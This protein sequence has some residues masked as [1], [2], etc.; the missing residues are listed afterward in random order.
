MQEATLSL[1]SNLGL[2]LW[3]TAVSGEPQGPRGCCPESALE[4]G[5]ASQ[6]ACHPVTLSARVVVRS[7]DSKAGSLGAFFSTQAV[8]LVP[9]RGGRSAVRGWSLR[10]PSPV[11]TVLAHTGRGTCMCLDGVH[12]LSRTRR[13][14]RCVQHGPQTLLTSGPRPPWR[15][16][17]G[18]RLPASGSAAGGAGTTE[19][20]FYLEETGLVLCIFKTQTERLCS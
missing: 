16:T 14:L 13:A 17:V 5:L 9:G 7:S 15:Q 4:L 12:K 1:T 10:K 2:L 19:P 3:N 20:F 6:V 8:L 11:N 18:R